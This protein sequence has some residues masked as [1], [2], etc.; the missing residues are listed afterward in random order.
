MG[1]EDLKTLPAGGTGDL[2]G[3]CGPNLKERSIVDHWGSQYLASWS[4]VVIANLKFL[5]QTKGFF[6]RH[7]HTV[8]RAHRNAVWD[9]SPMERSRRMRDP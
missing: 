9:E 4:I 1:F 3:I 8:P 2:L 6:V 5:S 7:H